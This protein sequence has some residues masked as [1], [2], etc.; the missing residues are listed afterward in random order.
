MKLRLSQEI[1]LRS[2]VNLST[3]SVVQLKKKSY[4]ATSVATTQRTHEVDH[5]LQEERVNAM[6]VLLHV[7]TKHHIA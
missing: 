6:L 4:L 1:T 7:V 5:R 2:E 3:V